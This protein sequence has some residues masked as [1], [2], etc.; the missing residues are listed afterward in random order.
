MENGYFHRRS[1]SAER[2]LPSPSDTPYETPRVS[3]PRLSSFGTTGPSTPLTNSTTSVQHVS[4]K[5]RSQHDDSQ[6]DP[7]Q[8]TPTLHASLVSE[9][10]NLRR[11]LDAKRDFIEDLEANVSSSRSENDSL[12]GNLRRQGKE[13]RALK[14]EL[15]LHEDGTLSAMEALAKER[16]DVKEANTELRRKSRASPFKAV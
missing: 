9:I 11:E 5:R 12:Q 3:S 15:Q 16:D 6:Y 4:S 2:P 7:E 1:Q 13:M 10:L 14:R 8:F